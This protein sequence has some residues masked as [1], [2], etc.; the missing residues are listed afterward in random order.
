MT[1][2]SIAWR[3]RGR[4]GKGWREDPDAELHEKF[5]TRFQEACARARSR[6]ENRQESVQTN[7]ASR[8]AVERGG[9]ARRA[10]RQSRLRVG[11]GRQGLAHAPREGGVA[12]RSDRPALHR[13]GNH[14]ARADRGEEG[15][16]GEGAPAAGAARRS[17][18]RARAQAR[19]SRRP[20]AEGSR[21]GRPRSPLGD[22]DAAER[23]APRARIPGRAPEGGARRARRRS[24]TSCARWTSGSGSPTPPSRRS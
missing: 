3:S 17:A 23:A 14:H 12:G 20:D 15:G 10:G 9:A 7:G 5:A 21:Q 18:D 22:R 24:S 11:L 2:R 8:G 19:G 16:R 4:S 13:G 1:M 6:H